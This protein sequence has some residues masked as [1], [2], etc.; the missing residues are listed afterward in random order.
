M[1]ASVCILTTANIEL[2]FYYGKKIVSFQNCTQDRLPLRKLSN[3]SAL[4]S[5]APSAGFFQNA[6]SPTEG[7]EQW[8]DPSSYSFSD[9]NIPLFVSCH[10]LTLPSCAYKY[11]C[12]IY[13]LCFHLVSWIFVI[14]I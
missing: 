14:H 1:L 12:P 10:W 13:I 7:T 9:L 5:A 8:P 6:N 4:Y 11:R 2:E 3:F